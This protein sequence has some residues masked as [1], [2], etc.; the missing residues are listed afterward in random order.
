MIETAWNTGLHLLATMPAWLAAF[1][2]GWAVS[3]GLTQGLKFALPVGAPEGLREAA[4]RW[5][6]FLSAAVPAGAWLYD[7]GS[8]GLA[9]AL[10]A[11]G[12]G[13]WSPIAYA[14]LIAGLRRFDRT[15]WIADVLSGDKRG[16]VKAKLRGES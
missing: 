10:V 8:S 2:I 12:T 4:A 13:A 11:I 15:A 7:A 5:L 14:L 16:V 3:V 9:V 6:A 1:L